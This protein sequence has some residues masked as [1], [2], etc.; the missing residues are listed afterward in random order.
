MITTCQFL[1]IYTEAIENIEDEI[2]NQLEELNIELTYSMIDVLGIL[3]KKG[4][5]E[6]LTNSLI[7]VVCE[8]AKKLVLEKFP[9]AEI[10]YDVAGYCSS[11]EILN[12]NELEI[13]E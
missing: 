12:I 8:T 4:D 7:E 13:E 2:I 6:F 11:F 3:K 1:R 5:W 9:N 10:Q